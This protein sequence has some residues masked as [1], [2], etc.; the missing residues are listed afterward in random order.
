MS[1]FSFQVPAGLDIGSDIGFAPTACI[2]SN[3]TG[4]YIYLPDGLNY[5]PPWTSGAVVPLSHATRARATWGNSPF[6]PQTITA[7]P[8]IIQQASL[9][10]SDNPNL[11][12]GGG[13]A[14]PQPVTIVVPTLFGTVFPLTP[15]VDDRF[16]R[17]DLAEEYYYDGTRWLSTIEKTL[18]FKTSVIEPYTAYFDMKAANPANGADILV[19]TASIFFF[20]V[21]P[22]VVPN[23][24]YMRL[25]KIPNGS[26]IA[27]Q[28]G[29]DITDTAGSTVGVYNV[30]T[31]LIVNQVITWATGAFIFISF[32]KLNTPGQLTTAGGS[33]NYRKIAV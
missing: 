12:L 20:G 30:P 32:Y 10:F 5:C 24:W 29:P 17:T 23:Y 28:V 6:G 27:T 7:I 3:Y 25:Y 1:D 18:F 13:T 8:G 14:I 4:Y 19:T 22:Q 26:S 2:I 31:P 11:Q 9:T 15:A 21:A 33:I 16:F